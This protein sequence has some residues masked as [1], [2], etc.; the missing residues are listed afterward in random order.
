MKTQ[1]TTREQRFLFKKAQKP[2]DIFEATRKE[3][4]E[5]KAR[6]MDADV[7]H[8]HDISNGAGIYNLL[9]PTNDKIVGISDFQGNQLDPGMNVAAG[10]IKIGYGK[11]AS[12]GNPKPQDILY[13]SKKT[14]FPKELLNA[15]PIDAGTAK[16]QKLVGS[17]WVT[18][19]TIDS[20]YADGKH[21]DLVPANTEVEYRIT[22]QSGGKPYTEQALVYVMATDFST[23][24]LE[25]DS[26][27]V[28]LLWNLT[29]NDGQTQTDFRVYRKN[30][31]D[32]EAYYREIDPTRTGG[33]TNSYSNLNTG[34]DK[35]DAGK[36]YSYVLEVI[37]TGGIVYQVY[38]GE[39]TF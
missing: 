20:L 3:I 21:V 38:L 1:D 26:N 9:L 34:T 32:G 19:N 24:K 22:Y 30:I 10:R 18:V 28:N 23:L 15:N 31:T 35:V 14:D 36:E 29:D 33:A 2:G 8:R 12:A 11:A 13:S 17:S 4:L 25:K 37:K 27:S 39:I 5:G 7:T 16:L 6:F